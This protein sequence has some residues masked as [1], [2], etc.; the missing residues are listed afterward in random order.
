MMCKYF[1]QFIVT[2]PLIKQL[3]FLYPIHVYGC[4]SEPLKNS[5]TTTDVWQ[6]VAELFCFFS[7]MLTAT[8][9]HSLI[10]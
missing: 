4:A 8:I 3:T 10:I 2:S 1:V 7:F 9:T 5:V 6:S